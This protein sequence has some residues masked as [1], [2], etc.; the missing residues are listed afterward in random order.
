[1]RLIRR[2]D[3]ERLGISLNNIESPFC[4]KFDVE[5]ALRSPYTQLNL[6]HV[7]TFGRSMSDQ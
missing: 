2:Q 6:F 4:A 5:R 3:R 1:M 7:D